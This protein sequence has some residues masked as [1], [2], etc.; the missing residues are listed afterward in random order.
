MKKTTLMTS[1]YR[2]MMSRGKFNGSNSSDELALTLLMWLSEREEHG[3][4]IL[5]DALDKLGFQ[6]IENQVYH[7]E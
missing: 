1:P 3:K 4:Q 5:I 2:S 6:V 7:E